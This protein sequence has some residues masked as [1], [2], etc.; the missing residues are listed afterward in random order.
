[1]AEAPAVA[2]YVEHIRAVRPGFALGANNAR[3]VVETC[4]RLD[5]L[6]LA[7]ELAAARTRAVPPEALLGLLDASLAVLS[8]GP[9]DLPER[10]QS[11][12]RAIDSSYTRLNPDVQN[13]LQRVAVFEGAFTEDAASA[14]CAP[15]AAADVSAALRMLLAHSL[16]SEAPHA[17]RERRFR[18]LQTLR[19]Y[20]REELS[21]SGELTSTQQRHAAY[22]AALAERSTAGLCADEQAIWLDRLD[23]AQAD[24]RAASR[25]S[26]RAGDRETELRLAGAL[27]RF[28]YMRGHLEEAGRSLEDALARA[29]GVPHAARSSALEGAAMIAS[30]RADWNHASARL[31]A[32]FDVWREQGEQGAAAVGLAELAF[33]HQQQRRLGKARE[34]ASE[35]VA[36]ARRANDPWS[37]A[38]A[39]LRAA[40]VALGQGQY[41][42]ARVRFSEALTIAHDLGDQWLS[43]IVLEGLGCV[44]AATGQPRRALTLLAGA[45]AVRQALKTPRHAAEQAIL[46][47]WLG[48]CRAELGQASA[49]EIEA[50][51]RATALG[52]L[53]ADALGADG[54]PDTAGANVTAAFLDRVL[55]RREREVAALVAQ[56]HSNRQISELLA[57]TEKT[58]E[59][60][61]SN[62]LHK[63]ELA[64]R[65]QLTAWVLTHQPLLVAA[66]SS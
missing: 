59:A 6:P 34:L 42:A 23:D 13:V 40:Q 28:W 53:V 35:A 21:A 62:I 27:W 30:A 39:L 18:L 56:G 63:L 51:G 46:E 25:W 12:R 49:A 15:A 24:L 61:V 3:S 17:P 64:R 31:E 5:G 58:A 52:D 47:W 32:S 26:I 48:P 55:T 22:F 20:A 2:L 4:A 36:Q 37:L 29:V 66:R 8:E 10:Q 41:P 44:S 50:E 14:V 57:F 9:L 45:T 54:R 33:V 38:R 65:A 16:I 43:T 60:H 19:Q 7:L 11:L 1:V